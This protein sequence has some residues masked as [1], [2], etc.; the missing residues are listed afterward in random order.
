[1]Q[2]GRVNAGG[3]LALL[4]PARTAAP[5][6]VTLRG[7]LS[8]RV[9]MRSYTRIVPAGTLTATLAFRGPRSLSLALAEDN[10]PGPGATTS[11]PS[12][13]RI[14]RPVPAGAV[15]IVVRALRPGRVRYVLTLR[16]TNGGG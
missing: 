14:V 15:R 5:A 16:Q 13:L 1:V 9:Q 3:T 2:Y 4:T 12:P 7:E 10:A 6:Q 11:G 8:S